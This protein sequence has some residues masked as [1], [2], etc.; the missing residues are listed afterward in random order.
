MGI[1][2]YPILATQSP[3]NRTV[4]VPPHPH[5]DAFKMKTTTTN[6]GFAAPAPKQLN[7]FLASK[8]ESGC[9]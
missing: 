8:V 9:I 5:G 1:H 4:H 3:T 2:R 6:Q 7:Y